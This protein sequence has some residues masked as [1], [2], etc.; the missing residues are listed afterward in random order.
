MKI[1]GTENCPKVS[2]G[3]AAISFQLAPRGANHLP[4]VPVVIWP[5]LT[6]LLSH[7]T[8]QARCVA[9]PWNQNHFVSSTPVLAHNP[10]LRWHTLR[11]AQ[12]SDLELIFILLSL[13]RS[14]VKPAVSSCL[15]TCS[16]HG[17][18]FQTNSDIPVD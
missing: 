1:Q 15:S 2:C 10:H 3:R 9:V 7:S 14:T 16:W 12:L 6:L 5:G 17:Q 8:A 4:L 18:I 13:S 11:G